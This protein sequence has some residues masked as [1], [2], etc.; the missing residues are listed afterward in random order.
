MGLE[1]M[2][3]LNKILGNPL[4]DIPIVHVTGTNGKGSC[5]LKIAR[6]LSANGIRTGL[7]VSPHISSFKERIQINGEF[8]DDSDVEVYSLDRH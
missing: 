2:L 8:V 1:N 5:S 4:K 6:A 7:F 3:S